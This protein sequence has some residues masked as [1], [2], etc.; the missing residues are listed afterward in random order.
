MKRVFVIFCALGIALAICAQKPQQDIKKNLRLSGGSFLAYPGPKQHKLTSAPGNK[1]PFYI[2]H[3]GRHGSRYPTKTEDFTF[4]IETLQKSEEAHALTPLGS[5]VLQ[6]VIMME[7]EAHNR[8]GELTSLGAQQQ[9]EIAERMVQRFPAVFEGNVTIE[10]KS[11]TSVRAILSMSNALLK[12]QALNPKLKIRV[13]ASQA[14]MGYL[15][16]NDK[17]LTTQSLDEKNVALYNAFVDAHS[18]WER[19]IGQLYSDTAYLNHNVEGKK[20]N[21]YLF[22][23]AS[24]VQD[25]DLRKKVTLYDLYTDAELYENWRKDNV[26]WY[27]GFGFAPTNGGKMPFGQRFLLRNIIEKADSCLKLDRPGVTLRYGHDT[28]LLPLVCLLGINDF[29]LS[30]DDLDQVERRGWADYKIIPMAGNLQ[31]IFYRNG[32]HDKDILVKVL[33]NENEATLPLKTDV[34]PYYHWEDFRDYYLQRITAY[35]EERAH[36]EQE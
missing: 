33:L 5:E 32:I 36:E 22:R 31:F 21:S 7:Q 1:K 13:D 25:M 8:P 24:V 12:L 14:D 27:L 35:D 6:R 10:A 9:Q 4:V 15:R 34:A 18:P 16:H 20:L 3:F 26:F 30:T 17:L 23:L 11:T 2:S 19:V 28:A 29:D